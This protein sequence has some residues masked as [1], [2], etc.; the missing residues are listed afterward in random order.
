[1][2][3]NLEAV[4]TGQMSYTDFTRQLRRDDLYDMT[5]GLFEAFE[6]ILAEATDAAVQFI[7]RDMAAAD[8]SEQGWTMSHIVTHFTASFEESAA[9][10]AMFARGFKVEARLRYETPW[11]SLSTREMVLARL[12][13]SHRMCRA[14]LDVWPYEPHLEITVNMIPHFGP[15]N[16][17][18]M[19]ALG[20]MHTQGHIEQMQEALA[21]Y[22]R[23]ENQ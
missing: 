18:G 14:F 2:N 11:E 19:Y 13:E 10:A 17:V 20:L 23:S 9:A 5:D 3:T 22:K 8:E 6:A 15:L 16:A 21:Q 1:M 4:R 7:P 12:R